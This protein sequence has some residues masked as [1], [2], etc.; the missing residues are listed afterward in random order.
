MQRTL[1]PEVMD[2]PEEAVEYDSMD[3]SGPND[4]FTTRLLELGVHGRVLDIG[5][6]PGHIPVLLCEKLAGVHVTGVDLAAHML[7]LAQRKRAASPHRHRLSF[8]SADAKGLRYA[9]GWFD[10]VCSNTILHHIPDPRPFLRECRRVLKPGGALLVRDLIRPDSDAR[11]RA[12]TEQNAAGANARQKALLH[13]SYCAA[14]TLEELRA[15]AAECG[16]GD[17]EVV[18]DDETHMSL[19]LSAR[20]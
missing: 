11:A 17:A 5:T 14:F 12:W 16:L 20:R 1:E 15:L 19:Q 6:G 7:A 3:H 2:T 13:A 9:G 8:E 4:R 10:S 18:Q